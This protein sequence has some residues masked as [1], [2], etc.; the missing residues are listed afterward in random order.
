M[1]DENGTVHT[2]SRD[3]LGRL[4]AD[5]VAVASGNPQNVDQSVLNHSFTYT[6][7]GLPLLSTSFSNAAG[8]GTLVNQVE[9]V[10]NG[11]GQ[12][13]I[14]YQSHSGAV[15]TSTT[16]KV[17][18]TYAGH[19]PARITVAPRRQFILT[20]GSW[21]ISTQSALPAHPARSR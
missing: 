1:Q 15:N 5:A 11:L 16:P 9:G 18:Y 2:Y 20:R 4:T 13:T 14:E 3:T 7:L 19:R 17:Q 10:Y 8:T 21:T 12:L 6:A